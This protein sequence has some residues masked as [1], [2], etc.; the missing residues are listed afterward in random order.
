MGTTVNS[1]NPKTD[2]TVRIYDQFYNFELLVP[3]DEYDAVLS[4]FVSVFDTKEAAGNFTVTLFRIADTSGVP[5]LSLLQQ[6]EGQG[7]PE[8]TFTLAYY[9]NN[10][11]SKSTLLGISQPTTPNYYIGR[12]VRA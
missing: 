7:A 6:L 3:V 10:F 8:L 9:L 1:A 11:R 5:V 12:N 2:R 4:Y